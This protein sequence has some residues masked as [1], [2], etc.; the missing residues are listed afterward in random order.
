MDN[1]VFFKNFIW[2]FL[3]RC[4]AQSITFIVSIVLARILEPVVFGLIALVTVFTTVMQVFIDSGL[5]N[6]LIQK[7]H[8]DDLDFS[9]VFYFNMVVC[10]FL[11]LIMFFFAPLIAHFYG[12]QDLV[13]IIRVLSLILIV[14]GVKNVQQAYVS[15]QLIFKKFFIA[16]LGGT[17]CAAI[18]G[19]WMAY[20]GWGVWALVGQ[21]LTNQIVGTIVLWG[22]VDWRPHLVFS[23]ERLKKLLTYGWKLL[24]SSLIDTLYREI[25]Q[26]IVGKLYAATELAF[27]NKGEEFPKLLALN[28]GTSIDSVLFP[29][30]SAV[31]DD[32]QR[33]RSM[34]RRAI[35]TSTYI[36]MPMM[37][38]LAVC[39]KP[40]VMLILT[41]K[42]LFCIPF[43]RI[44]CFTYA[45]YPVH[46]ANLNA[47]KAMGR[48]DLFLKLEIVKKII[49]IVALL[50]TMWISVMAMAYSLLVVSV[51]SQIIN[52]WPNRKLLEYKYRDQLRDM[53]PQICLSVIM[54]AI[55]YLI[56]FLQINSVTMLLIQIITGIGIYILGSKI[57]KI[58]SFEYLLSVICGL[59]K[60]NVK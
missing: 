31:Q 11:Y 48:S 26:L 8:A 43:L 38:G 32:I 20:T 59:L 25:R 30:M 54:G 10:I 46:T 29:T 2:R 56:T 9:T 39:A 37:M 60:R 4:G 44:F 45:F 22:M 40:L 34:T 14:S 5:G 28:I 15:R 3:E 53:C 47:I 1:K 13:P 51:L 6:A 57:F 12:M 42:W 24:V 19:L 55:V 16:T 58:D 21:M 33:I 7:K 36:M 35:K 41:D 18:V 49:G 52:S 50:V 23:I 27:Y 17:V